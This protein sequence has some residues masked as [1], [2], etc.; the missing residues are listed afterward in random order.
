MDLPEEN[1]RGNG[2][3]KVRSLGKR[4]QLQ[5]DTTMTIS[6]HYLIH[7]VSM[8]DLDLKVDNHLLF[9]VTQ[10]EIIWYRRL[11]LCLFL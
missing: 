6:R 3:R 10:Y 4:S 11:S 5:V 9:L 8:I 1:T 2:K 7:F